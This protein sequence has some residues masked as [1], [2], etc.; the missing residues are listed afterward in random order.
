MFS[1]GTFA[2]SGTRALEFMISIKLSTF[3]ESVVALFG[4]SGGEE[5]FDFRFHYQLPRSSFNTGLSFCFFGCQNKTT[6]ELLICEV[7]ARYLFCM[8]PKSVWLR[9]SMCAFNSADSHSLGEKITAC[10]Y[11]LIAFWLEFKL[12]SINNGEDSH[13]CVKGAEFSEPKTKTNWK[14]RAESRKIIC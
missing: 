4:S 9:A 7:Y 14:T 8:Q 13:T 10:C 3:R 2:S 11:L 5:K 12:F 1:I 6:K